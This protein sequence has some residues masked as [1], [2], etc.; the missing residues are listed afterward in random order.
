MNVGPDTKPVAL[1]LLGVIPTG[2]D[3]EIH[4]QADAGRR[5]KEKVRQ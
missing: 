3:A 1:L 2:T 5:R 4:G